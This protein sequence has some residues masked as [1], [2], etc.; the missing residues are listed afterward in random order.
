MTKRTSLPAIALLLAALVACKSDPQATA[1]DAFAK[2][3]KH[4]AEKRV[5]EAIIEY[6]RA[7][8]AD[9]RLG[10]ARL[11][12]AEA[13]VETG[14]PGNALR[15]YVR[16][17]ELLPD[18][19]DAQLKAGNFMLA[20]GLSQDAH[21]LGKRMLAR[22]PGSVEAQVLV[23]QSLAALK[24]FDGAKAAF[25]KAIE[26]Q[27]KRAGT[28]AD[29]GAVEML[30]GDRAKAEAAFMKAI[31]TDENSSVAHLALANFRWATGDLPAAER[32]LKRALELEPKNIMAN[33]ALGNLYMG[34][35]R[36]ELAEPYFRTVADVAP[37]QEGKF[38]LADYYIRLRKI[39]SARDVLK[40][41][42]AD[43]ASYVEA[44]VRLAN[45]EA[46][47]EKNEEA[48]RILDGVLAKDP[49]NASALVTRGKLL[50]VEGNTINALTALKTA[51]DANPRSLEAR[52][53]LGRTHAIR[54]S[55]KEAIATYNE[56]LTIDG[57]S[58]EARMALA[59]LQIAN[60]MAA[61]AVPLLTKVVEQQPYNLNARLALFQ[62]LMA[63][64]DLPQATNQVAIMQ[65]ISPESA[66]VHAAAGA[67]AL[68]KKDEAGARA[69][70]SR[71]LA[72]NPQSYQALAGL[73][74]AEMRAKNIGSVKSL[75]EKQLALM[76]NDPNVLLLGAQ[77]YDA[78]GD[79]A[80]T[81]RLLK[82]TVQADPASLQAYTMLGKMYYQQGRLDMARQEL[83]K[84]VVTAPLSVPGNTML[85]TILQLQ[86]KQD[87]A[88]ARYSKALQIDSRSAVAANNLAWIDAL[89]NK[90]LDVALQLA[91]TAKAQIPNSH[92][93]D[94]TL[95]YIYYKKGLS[96]MAIESLS[97]SV[98]R[99]P[100]NPLYNYH[101]ALAHHANG[102]KVEARK[103][104]EKALTSK[105]KFAEADE[106]KKL[107]D[108][109]KG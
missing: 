23:A 25:D 6:R 7:I 28:Y 44:S 55:L 78:I 12:L 94:D 33:R 8:Q 98:L 66:S 14:D 46:S 15:S 17:A 86:G 53:A 65:K 93:V 21:D 52:L 49:K 5:N 77:A 79:A 48:H 57:N 43:Q 88:R 16:A 36:A 96:S 4:F 70:Y 2:G 87:E 35:R 89:S 90:N 74:T 41:M 64:G 63:A 102:N 71:A 91:Q 9:P 24:D 59:E 106:A 108:S 76:P 83:E 34:T 72:A 68:M 100:D 51:A 1:R 80:E 95:G 29:L 32:S 97:N 27:P 82:K 37:G 84:F 99:Q 81:E 109:I 47:A 60:G 62:G 30:R 20:S 56:A 10:Q 3:E 54:G 85:G 73:L 39:D 42:T 75:I 13:Y 104:L 18:D 107:L 31:E 67:L 61:D 19:T 11:R 105:A 45:L 38:A 40:P 103:L 22:T 58:I 92:Q 50:L 26:M 101:L 69:A